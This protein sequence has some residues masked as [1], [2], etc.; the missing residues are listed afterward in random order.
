MAAS[1][2]W[3]NPRDAAAR[4]IEDGDIVRVFNDR[5]ACLAGAR[6]SADLLPGVAQ[7]PTGA[8]YDPHDDHLRARQ[9]ERADAGYRDLQ[10]GPGP[11]GAVMPGAG[12]AL[13][14]RASPGYGA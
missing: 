12:R 6:L 8:W 5:G 3:L 14:G 7:L 1:R 10:P 11:G 4:G 2:S 13:L 9:P